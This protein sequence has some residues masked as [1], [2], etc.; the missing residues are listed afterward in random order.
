MTREFTDGAYADLLVTARR[1][2]YALLTV[3]EYLTREELPDRFLLLRHDVDRKPANALRFARLEERLGVESTY[4]VRTVDG[5]FDPDLVA[6]I[7]ALGH[8]VGYHYEDLDRARGDP[9]RARQSFARN[10]AALRRHATVDT[11]C[12]HGNPLTPFDNSALWEDSADLETFD[13][14]GD[15]YLSVDFADVTYFSDAGRTWRDGVL[16]VTDPPRCVHDKAVQAE[17][18]RDLKRLFADG[19]VQR[20]CVLSHPNRWADTYGELVTEAAKDRLVNAG[21]RGLGVLP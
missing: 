21:K 8:E 13:L 2:G 19:I 14:L 16:K 1:T 7:E 20:A 5:T 9:S 11:V 3:R 4:Y 12:M 17:T 18:T 10:L 6:G 15:A